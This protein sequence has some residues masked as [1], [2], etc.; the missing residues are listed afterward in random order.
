MFKDKLNI[1]IIII[2]DLKWLKIKKCMPM[3][4]GYNYND[5]KY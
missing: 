2:Y 3:L 1:Q 5:N 4:N